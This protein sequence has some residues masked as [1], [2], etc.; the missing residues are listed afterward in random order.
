MFNRG[1]FEWTVHED[2]T[3]K[4]DLAAE[5]SS[6]C[7]LRPHKLFPIRS[8]IEPHRRSHLREQWRRSRKLRPALS[9]TWADSHQWEMY[10]E[11]FR[12]CQHLPFSR[13]SSGRDRYGRR[14]AGVR[15][16]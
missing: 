13:V 7:S 9:Q 15:P 2:E 11:E 3:V 8:L 14:G 1:D 4:H 12:K 5:T 6:D 10:D 16:V